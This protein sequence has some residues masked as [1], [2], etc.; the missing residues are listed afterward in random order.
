[1]HQVLTGGHW[2]RYIVEVDAGRIV[3][4]KPVASDRDPS[5]LHRGLPDI[6][7]SPVRTLRPSIRAGWLK[8]R[9]GS[10]RSKRGAEPFVAVPWDEAIDMVA[11]EI[12]RVRDTF[13]NESIYAGSYGWAS[14]GRLHHPRTLFKKLL[15]LVGGFTDHVG[16]YSR[17]A[18]LVIVPRV[19]GS[20]DPVGMK[21]TAWDS[22]VSNT[23]QIVCFG[24]L[25]PKNFQIDS[26]G[27]GEHLGNT[28]MDRVREA[29]IDV[30]YVGPLRDDVADSLDALWLPIRPNTDTAMMLAI[31]H[32]L[33]AEDLHDRTFLD[34]YCVGFD[35]FARY[36]T[37]ESDGV[38]KDA[39]WASAICE[40]EADAIRDL[41][42]RMVAQRTIITLAYSLQRADHGEQP[43]WA[44]ITLAAMLG[45]I[46]LPG[47]GFGIG[48]GS[49]GT[50]GGRR[51]P[52]ALRS[53]AAG[54]NPTKRFIPVSRIT[55]M[56]LSPG[57]TIDFNGQRITYPDVRLM[58]WGGGSPFHHHQ[59]LNRF[60][61]A[62]RRPETIVVTEP[63]WSPVARHAD[64]VL[65]VATTL[66]RN[67]ISAGWWDRT[68]Y[69]MQ[70]AIE[71]VGESRSD[72]DI[73]GALAD[74]LGCGEAFR[75]GRDEKAWIADLY[76]GL[77]TPAARRG[78]DLPSFEAFWEA[79]HVDL[80][81]DEKP[82]VMFEDFRD[83][84]DAHPLGTPSGRIEIFS[85]AIDSFG[86]DDC[87]GHPVWKEP[88]E[89]LGS[90]TARTYP[91]HLI[92]NQ[93]GTR[94]HS[95]NDPSEHSR[96]GKTAGRETVHISPQDAEARGIADGDIVRLFN[97]RGACLAG[98]RISP[99]LRLGVIQLP[100]GAWY[101]PAD[102][103]VVGTLELHGNPNVLTIDKGTSRL[104]Q[105][106]IAHSALVEVE[107]WDGE[108]L[109]VRAFEP[110]VVLDSPPD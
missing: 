103:G 64:I 50:K 67:D 22:I 68:V 26:G 60:V 91:L 35:T 101:D 39:E 58:F 55:D 62:W 29:G 96:A 78:M 104:A 77:R 1:M 6:V 44:S 49:M 86:Y 13:G 3:G 54:G 34:R 11:E 87:P 79:G 110:P 33:I 100:T 20:T 76:E 19:V 92:S 75:E 74:R 97:D 108:A 72:F 70:Q 4:V 48:Y 14:A 28:W 47:G 65:P 25:A 73:A 15:N 5:P 17:G 99:S 32:T 46:G 84:P 81:I 40:I 36:V 61:E 27:M 94:L 51:A 90:E 59:D 80:P 107:R 30:T 95:Q 88:V 45:Q 66:E 63:F 12:D 102:P 89:W 43:M 8:H 42:R 83:D 82:Y 57:E 69:A 24:G 21:L 2:G 10:D 16:D 23:R 37:G 85:K 9:T 41:A 98:A 71:P 105:A 53:M 38:A 31:A 52:A 109:P 7:D 106:P 93:P 56:L 18:A